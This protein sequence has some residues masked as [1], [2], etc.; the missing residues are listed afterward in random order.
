MKLQ[1]PIMHAMPDTMVYAV[2]NITNLFKQI[3]NQV[4][5]MLDI[6]LTHLQRSWDGRVA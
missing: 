2:L 3:L 4:G 6:S 5:M 1:D